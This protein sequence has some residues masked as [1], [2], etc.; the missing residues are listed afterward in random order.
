M[1]RS[2]VFVQIPN[3]LTAH[4][5]NHLRIKFFDMINNT[6]IICKKQDKTA[7]PQFRNHEWPPKGKYD[8]SPKKKLWKV[9][10]YTARKSDRAQGC[11]WS[12]L[13]YLKCCL[14]LLCFQKLAEIWL[15]RLLFRFPLFYFY[16][17]N[18]RLSKYLISPAILK[19][20]KRQTTFWKYQ[21][22]GE[23]WVTKSN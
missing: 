12:V 21:D 1:N 13:G 22:Q 16:L 20:H 5:T 7:L 14:S 18:W 23:F 4:W 2:H 9:I 8:P 6:F 11:S 3:F 10:K 15:F 17:I 19:A